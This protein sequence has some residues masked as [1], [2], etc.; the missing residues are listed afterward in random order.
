MP[1]F[2]IL[3]H[4]VNISDRVADD[5]KPAALWNSNTLKSR[6]THWDLMFEDDGTLLTWAVPSKP[7]PGLCDLAWRLPDHRLAYLDYE[8]EISGGRG[9][10][11]QVMAGTFEFQQRSENEIHIQVLPLPG[12]FIELQVQACDQPENEA[13]QL[14]IR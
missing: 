1:R 12:W 13:W 7:E 9:C 4:E 3:H 8:G 6:G 2:V 10:V 14:K 11:T 5:S